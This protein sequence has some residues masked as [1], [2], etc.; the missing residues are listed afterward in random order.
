MLQ[1]ITRAQASRLLSRWTGILGDGA[2]VLKEKTNGYRLDFFAWA[3]NKDDQVTFIAQELRKAGL[4]V[5]MDAWTLG[6]GSR[7]WEQIEGY[8]ANSDAW[9]FV[10]THAS[11]ASQPCREELAMALDKALRTADNP[12]PVVG[13]FPG[14]VNMELI[15]TSIRTRLFVTLEQVDWIER[16]KAAAERRAPAI[17]EKAIEPYLLKV[18]QQDG[19]FAIELR[20]RAGQWAPALVMVP[21][22]ECEDLQPQARIEPAGALGRLVPLSATSRGRRTMG[23]GG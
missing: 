23:S 13:L 12:F 5:Q 4:T 20:P 22:N 15:P 3:D 14:H 1:P 2:S 7:L 6:A 21:L 8:I 9:V 17:A 11:L 10:A 16:I 19:A 18:H